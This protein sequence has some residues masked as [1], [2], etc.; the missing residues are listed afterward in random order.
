MFLVMIFSGGGGKDAV[1]N[2][3]NARLDRNLVAFILIV[4]EGCKD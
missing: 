2:K 1:A 3:A 4:V